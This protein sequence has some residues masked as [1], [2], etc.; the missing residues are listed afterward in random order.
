MPIRFHPEAE[1]EMIEQ[2]RYYETRQEGLGKRFLESVRASSHQIQ[3]F[4]HLFQ[5]VDNLYRRCCLKTFP[6]GLVFRVKTD[7]IQI[8]AVIPFRRRP[9]YWKNRVS[10]EQD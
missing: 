9:G 6:F 10:P 7:E 1:Q 4:P 5:A 8:I 2:A 3:L